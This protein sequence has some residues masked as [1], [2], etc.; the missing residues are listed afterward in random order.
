VLDQA[1]PDPMPAIPGMDADAIWDKVLSPLKKKV[2][3]MVQKALEK[4]SDEAIA[5]AA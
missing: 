4:A 2:R 5:R 3:D 1:K